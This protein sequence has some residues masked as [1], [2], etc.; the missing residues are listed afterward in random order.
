MDV[1][2]HGYN[3][4]SKLKG[5]W[6]MNEFDN[7]NPGDM[8]QTQSSLPVADQYDDLKTSSFYNESYKKPGKGKSRGLILPLIAV[9]LISSLLTGGIVTS[10]FTFFAAPQET[11]KG[12]SSNTIVTTETP[13]IRQVEIINE[14]ESPVVAIAEKVGPSVVGVQVNYTYD[15]MFFGQ[16]TVGGQGSGIIFRSDGYIITNNHV[17]EQAMQGTSNQI[18]KGATIQIVLPDK[19][20]NPIDATVIGRDAKTDIAILKINANNLP[21]VEFGDSDKLKVGELA[22]A[23]GNPAGLEFMGSVTAGYISGLNRSIQFDDGRKMKLIQTD[24]AINPGNSGG[25]L[26][27]GKGQVIGI[28]SSKIG[29]AGYEGLGF[30]IPSNVAKQVAESLIS[31]G[32][33]KGRP[34]LGIGVDISFTKEIAE[35]NNVPHGIMVS[36]VTPLS[37]AYRAGVKPNDIITKFNGV[38]ISTFEELEEE[39][40]KFKSG[41][42]IELEIYRMPEKGEP[43]E[44]TFKTV[45]VV[46]GEDKG[47]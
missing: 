37:A 5:V 26:V 30:A 38:E 34:Q 3:G 22:V 19:E 35:D 23:I 18:L 41:D 20:E 43:S 47:K 33:V 24:A 17:I 7:R 9:S 40:N 16:Q 8:T 6:P 10:Y 28:N 44:G 11:N 21:A 31:D 42:S 27:N 25:A 4:F 2:I 1:K 13:G 39:K 36:S 29:I 14:A 32:Y 46:L 45:T 15:D 12:N